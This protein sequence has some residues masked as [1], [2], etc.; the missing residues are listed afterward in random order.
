MIRLN[1]PG[2]FDE[3]N[4]RIEEERQIWAKIRAHINE[5]KSYMGLVHAIEADV[6]IHIIPN[7]DESGAFIQKDTAVMA[8]RS[9][10]EKPISVQEKCDQIEDYL[11]G[12]ELA[13]QLIS[14]IREGKIE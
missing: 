5:A 1:E 9:I 3:I 4:P 13:E 11:H 6:D 10:S 14:F 7:S 12:G 2:G 8:L